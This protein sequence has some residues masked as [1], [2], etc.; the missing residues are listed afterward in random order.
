M[1]INNAVITGSF[2]VNGVDVTGITGSSAISSSFLALSSSYVITSA[3]YAQSSASLS[4]RTSNLEATSSTVS[5]SFAATSASISSRVTN[6]EATSSTVSSSFATTSGSI[7]SRVTLIEGQYATTG[8][9][10]FTKPQQI[11]DVSNAIGFAST[12]SL[13]TDG[14][15]RVKGAAFISG[16]A[17]FNDVV[18]YGT[19]SIE[20]ITSS[21]IAIGTN[22]ITLNT[23]TPAIRFG[24]IS[25]FDSGSNNLSTGSLFWDSE[26][27]K[28]IYSNPS[29]STYDGGM[30]ISG[31]RNTSGLGNEVGTT[32][33]ALMMGQGGDHITSS[34]I[35]S[36]GNATCFYGQSYIS[37]SGTACF[38][39]QIC[40]NT[41]STIST[42]T[43]CNFVTSGNTLFGI[44]LKGRASDNF[45]AIGFYSS[46]GG[47]RYGYIQSHCTNGGQLIVNGDGGGQLI[48][49]NRGVVLTNALTGTTACFGNTGTGNNVLLISNN[50]Q[51]NTRLRITNTGS[52]GRT[53][54]IVGGLNGANNSSLS[55][56][57]ETASSTRLEINS[58]GITCFA[59]QICAPQAIICGTVLGD[60]FGSGITSMSAWGS[61]VAP[62]IEGR[63][64]NNIG[65]YIG[66]PEMY[67]ISN[68][69]Y[70]GT[71][72]IKKGGYGSAGI[73][74]SGYNQNILFQG[75]TS[76][77]AGCSFSFC[78]LIKIDTTTGVSCFCNTVCSSR[79]FT[80]GIGTFLSAVCSNYVVT[81][82]DTGDARWL[83]NYVGNASVYNGA[84]DNTVNKTI[85]G[86]SFN[87]YSECWQMGATRGSS[88]DIASFVIGRNGTTLGVIGI[89]GSACFA[90]TVCTP[91][92]NP[93]NLSI[94]TSAL[95]GI[96]TFE[97]G[98]ASSFTIN[99]PAEYPTLLLSGGNVWGI[100]GKTTFFGSGG[101]VEV[102]DFYIGRNSGGS[103]SS[104][105]YG[106]SSCTAAIL[107]SVVGS[108]TCIIINMNA[109][110]YITTEITAMVR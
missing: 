21:Q 109:N 73:V 24:G 50:D 63:E 42:T 86:L 26:K 107:Q 19:S 83:Q 55:I 10:T 7:S 56:Y 106:P 100:I 9:N 48:L 46:D 105:N 33:C 79:F 80:S 67:V 15:L 59:C 68:G 3:S 27:D 35:F 5:S 49:D 20:Y 11:T 16:T 23:D 53:Y 62:I 61:P 69:Y 39:G 18:V 57:D 64:G 30:L 52:G 75:A 36:Y 14:G 95:H 28:W 51:S 22:L 101:T 58:T 90:G 40:S 31:P 84:A 29:A 74:L 110:S 8:S 44:T 78:T 66:L 81:F 25:V 103:W 71:S 77:G 102:R 13:Y 108:G 4:I 17:Y 70:N 37:S 65:N 88:T 47:T 99:L 82:C 6:L 76:Q 32:S 1:L 97:G 104:A 54:S 92:A 34:A 91:L 12:A 85:A 45:G 41:L 89:G 72:Y 98:P 2:I 38:S 87:W 43:A 60:R 96:K 93:R 94:T